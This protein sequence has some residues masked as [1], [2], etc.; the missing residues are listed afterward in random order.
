MSGP[1]GDGQDGGQTPTEEP[2]TAPPLPAAGSG[3][4]A[5]SFGLNGSALPPLGMQPFDTN[6]AGS[7]GHKESPPPEAQ[8]VH[9]PWAPRFGAQF[10]ALSKC[11]GSGRAC[12]V[13]GARVRALAP[14]DVPATSSSSC[15]CCRCAQ[16]A[17][18]LACC[19]AEVG[20][21]DRRPPPL[22]ARPQE[23]HADAVPQPA[24]HGTARAGAPVS[25]RRWSGEPLGTAA[26]SA[27]AGRRWRPAPR[28]VH[29]HHLTT[30]STS[31]LPS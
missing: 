22:A 18:A 27:S 3:G 31:P 1:T 10:V 8:W 29:R 25:P 16:L 4:A 11:A 12:G 30:P 9:R 23:E 24:G 17:P 26:A 7:D 20:S 19:I 21:P 13:V 5:A 14:V 2:A 6:S 15:S 28:R